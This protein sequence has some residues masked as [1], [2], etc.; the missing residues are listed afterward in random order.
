MIA[1]KPKRFVM[2][3]MESSGSLY[4]LDRAKF[5]GMRVL[6]DPFDKSVV[7]AEA[8]E[9]LSLM[10]FKALTKEET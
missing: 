2:V 8:D 7:I 3:R 1:E 6:G 4:V 5:E 10:R 9:M